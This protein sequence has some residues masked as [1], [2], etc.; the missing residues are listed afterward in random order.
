[1]CQGFAVFDQTAICTAQFSVSIVAFW[2]WVV[3]NLFLCM[4][5]AQRKNPALQEK[6]CNA[7]LFYKI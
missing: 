7:G 4:S 2:R 6:T 5:L 3:N 1:V